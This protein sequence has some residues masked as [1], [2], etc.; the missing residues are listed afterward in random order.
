MKQQEGRETALDKVKE[1]SKSR[2]LK[3]KGW[4]KYK[5]RKGREG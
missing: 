3:T 5:A 1:Q 2:G 4:V